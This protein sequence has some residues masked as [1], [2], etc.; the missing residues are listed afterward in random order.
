MLLNAIDIG[1]GD[2]TVVL[3]HGMMGSAESWSRVTD[4]LVGQGDRVIAVDLP[5]H[6]LSPRDPEL[7]MASAAASVLE[8]V[9]ALDPGG[10]VVGVGH[11]YGSTVLAAAH[12]DLR[13]DL[14]IHVDAPLRFDGGADRAE[15]TAQYERDR[16]SRTV[17]GLR[18]S[19]PHSSARDIE[20]EARAARRFDPATSASVSCGSGG[21]WY[22]ASG[23]IVVLAEPSRFVSDEDARMLSA[24]GLEVR[25]IPGAEH[26]VW[27]SHFDE[28]R[29]ALPELFGTG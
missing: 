16:R 26:T 28:F 12:A 23:A 3:L 1:D 8:T 5:G 7:T 6:G 27:Y 15:L 18:A 20:V 19:R 11:S 24:R 29:A 17:E 13:P 14:A 10:E 25:R 4:V 22:P 9:R 21:A 2:R